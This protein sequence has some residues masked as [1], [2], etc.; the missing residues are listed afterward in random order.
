[1][2]VRLSSFFAALLL[3]CCLGGEASAQTSS[4]RATL[5]AQ[6][7][8][9]IA[10]NGVG[11]ITGAKLNGMLGNM[12]ASTGTL[13]DQNLFAQI[14]TF[15]LSPIIPTAPVGTNNNQAASTQF[16][17]S[18]IA[19]GTVHL[20]AAE[21]FV[22]NASGNAMAVPVSG[23]CGITS[24]GAVTCTK[25]NGVLFAPSATTDTTNASNI[26][27][28]TLPP[29]I[30]PATTVSA[31]NYTNANITVGADGRLTAATSG[32][33]SNLFSAPQGYLTP[34][35]IS[36]GTPVTGC[37]VGNIT[38]TSNVTSATTLYYEPDLG[39][40]VPIWNGTNFITYQVTE[41]QMTLALSSANAANTIY[42]VCAALESSVPTL[43]TSVAWTTST[44]GAGSRGTGTGTAQIDKTTGGLW[45]NSVSITGKNGANT[46][47]IPAH[48][49]TIVGSI[50]IDGTAG[51]VSLLSGFGQNRKWAISNAYNR[52]P[53]RLKA[54]DSTASWNTA[55]TLGP[56][57]GNAA[58]SLT[59]FN[60]FAEE[61]ADI[62]YISSVAATVG[63]TAQQNIGGGIGLNSTTAAT[64]ILANFGCSAGSSAVTCIGETVA[65]FHSPPFLGINVYTALESNNHSAV[66]TG[67]EAGTVLSAQWRG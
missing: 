66:T 33:V 25:T 23:D 50:F 22:G 17:V 59:V 32:A 19:V 14:Q 8:A 39:S 48:E 53:I 12:I 29:T 58:N 1:L 49:C 7:N 10:P 57:N 35:Q 9:V 52:K 45:T 63:A 18:Q 44:A 24:P 40:Q 60:G 54:G 5:Q 55:G 46:Y 16:V 15:N 61:P 56:I 26:T 13:L 11:S 30:I 28:G 6:D 31:G 34:C 67:T 4:T 41:A 65:E 20:P 47:T 42:D 3:G 43:V 27:S 51:Q 64:G 2:S 62:R 36:S 37:V 21:I 38:P